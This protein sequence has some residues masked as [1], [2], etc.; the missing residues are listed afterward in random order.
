M[1]NEFENKVEK[2]M[3]KFKN[4]GVKITI[5][6]VIESKFYMKNLTYKIEEGILVIEDGDEAYLDVDIDDIEDIYL[7]YSSSGYAL[8]VFRVGRDLQVEIQANDDNVIPIKDKLWKMCNCS[9]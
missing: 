2:A 5:S 6:G 4:E 3:K 8:V 9:T 1:E 7:E